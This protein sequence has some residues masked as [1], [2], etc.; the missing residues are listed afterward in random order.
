MTDLSTLRLL[1][2]VSMVFALVLAVF[3]LTTRLSP[4]LPAYLTF[5]FT[6]LVGSFAARSIHALEQ[7]VAALE[8][9][10]QSS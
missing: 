4:S 1:A 6:G 5:L 2:A 10:R 8:V 3:A 9:R 7:R